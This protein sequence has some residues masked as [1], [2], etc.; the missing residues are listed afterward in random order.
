[1]AAT[2]AHATGFITLDNYST[3]GPL[4]TYGA[5]S[6]GTTGSG[7]V[8]AEWTVSVYDSL[9]SVIVASD[10]TGTA[11][12]STLGPLT[13]QTGPNSTATLVLFPGT[14][15]ND[16]TGPFSLSGY[17]SGLVTLEVVAYNGS[18]FDSS[19]VRG[20][21]SAFMMTPGTGFSVPPAIGIAM[22]GF[23]VF[24]VVPEPSMLA[25]SG[26][27]AAALMLSRRKK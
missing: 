6:G 24:T 3:S 8:G 23:S 26:I 19:T 11:D 12:P 27:G 13:L 15:D 2:S 14:F 20:H 7:I 9:G 5:G 21:S 22:P 17:S 18:T 4:I 25:V 16:N 1:M 10:P